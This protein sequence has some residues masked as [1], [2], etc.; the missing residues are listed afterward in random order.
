M[1]SSLD[2]T[3][4]DMFQLFACLD[5]EISAC[6]WESDRYPLSSISRPDVQSRVSRPTVDGKEVQISVKTCKYRIFLPIF[7]QI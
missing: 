3:T 6:Q 4:A 5:K 7:D 1:E 2:E